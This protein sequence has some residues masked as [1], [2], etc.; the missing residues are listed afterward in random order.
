MAS[1]ISVLLQLIRPLGDKL[2]ISDG[3]KFNT[4][5]EINEIL[6]FKEKTS[7][8]IFNQYQENFDNRYATST[9]G[10]IPSLVGNLEDYWGI[11]YNTKGEQQF[12]LAFQ[13]SI[14]MYMDTEQRLSVE[15]TSPFLDPDEGLR[16]IQFSEDGKYIAE[17]CILG[18]RMDENKKPVYRL[19]SAERV[20]NGLPRDSVWQLGYPRLI[21]GNAYH[22]EPQVVITSEEGH[23]LRGRYALH[24]SS[25]FISEDGVYQLNDYGKKWCSPSENVDNGWYKNNILSG[26]RGIQY[27][28]KATFYE[29]NRHGNYYKIIAR[30][31]DL[32]TM[33]LKF[34]IDRE[35]NKNRFKDESFEKKPESKTELLPLINFLREYPVSEK[36]LNII[37]RL[38]EGNLGMIVELANEQVEFTAGDNKISTILGINDALLKILNS[39]IDR[40]GIVKEGNGF[41]ELRYIFD[42][43]VGSERTNVLC[44][45]K[46]STKEPDAEHIFFNSDISDKTWFESMLD[47]I[48]SYESLDS[49]TDPQL[50]ELDEKIL[51]WQKIFFKSNGEKRIFSNGPDLRQYGDFEDET[52]IELLHDAVI[53]I[54]GRYT[55]TKMLTGSLFVKTGSI[56]FVATSWASFAKESFKNNNR[57]LLEHYKK[58]SLGLPPPQHERQTALGYS[59]DTIIFGPSRRLKVVR[60][61]GGLTQERILNMP[62]I[63]TDNWNP[64]YITYKEVAKLGK[65]QLMKY[66]SRLSYWLSDVFG[67]NPIVSKAS[68]ELSLS[69]TEG[70][71]QLLEEIYEIMT[72]SKDVREYNGNDKEFYLNLMKDQ[73][74]QL[75]LL[76]WD[77]KSRASLKEFMIDP[78][79]FGGKYTIVLSE[80]QDVPETFRKIDLNLGHIQY[81]KEKGVFESYLASFRTDLGNAPDLDT[82]SL[83]SNLGE[84]ISH[85]GDSLA[86][87]ALRFSKENKKLYLIPMKAYT[88]GYAQKSQRQAKYYLQT[89]SDIFSQ[90][91]P[92][93]TKWNSWELDGSKL[94]EFAPKYK[95]LLRTLI[96]GRYSLFVIAVDKNTGGFEHVG[97]FNI[98]E[99]AFTP[100]YIHFSEKDSGYR[101]FKEIE[102]FDQ[103]FSMEINQVMK[104]FRLN[105]LPFTRIIEDDISNKFDFLL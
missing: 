9:D 2:S 36:T 84:V 94:S 32:T 57:L 62:H 85:L 70:T 39:Y 71:R 99:G 4:I 19:F 93:R 18:F 104:L 48:Q 80:S 33:K 23:I 56:L 27:G 7:D 30:E 90:P 64:S 69:K 49:L 95:Y 86:K 45:N 81:W 22:I 74:F 14:R 52:L 15:K 89:A 41:K 34:Q 60:E 38:I 101:T 13:G 51:M 67:Y 29:V 37:S 44:L 11:Q 82:S 83:L 46:Y 102:S 28:F 12:G 97:A 16:D 21:G 26:Y 55:Y 88:H 73:L 92:S 75:L 98:M 66:T 10:F 91:H 65:G 100:S 77:K 42:T 25:Y 76:G 61:A 20:R 59:V 3:Y 103:E 72:S 87:A 17:Q 35:Y 58:S 40:N 5:K 68:M 54:F 53:D 47:A 50:L 24:E 79:N 6:G 31:L 8:I 105:P 43:L 96:E 78:S 1:I 63:P